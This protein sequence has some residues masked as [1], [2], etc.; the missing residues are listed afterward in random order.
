MVNQMQ[1]A[2]LSH[3]PV[4]LHFTTVIKYL[5]NRLSIV[6]EEGETLTNMFP[7]GYVI[8]LGN[9]FIWDEY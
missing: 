7:S 3:K 1:G 8:A 4:S 9:V 2:N 5:Q 6:E